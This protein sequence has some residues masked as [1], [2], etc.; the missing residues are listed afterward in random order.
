M[1]CCADH[2]FLIGNDPPVSDETIITGLAVT[3]TLPAAVSGRYLVIGSNPIN[4]PQPGKPAAPH[5]DGLFQ[6]PDCTLVKLAVGPFSDPRPSRPIKAMI[7]TMKRHI[8]L[9][10]RITPVRN[11]LSERIRRISM[12][13]WVTIYYLTRNPR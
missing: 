10:I 6:A 8:L 9:F 13:K 2:W 1:A 7:K 4:P 5:V 3:G 11:F 12:K